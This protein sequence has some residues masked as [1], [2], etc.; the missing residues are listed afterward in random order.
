LIEKGCLAQ[1]RLRDESHKSMVI[2]DGLGERIQRRTVRLS[3]VKVRGVRRDAK[4]LLPQVKK[5]ENHEGNLY[6]MA[7]LAE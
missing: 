1:A 2:Q 4:R 3:R 7:P 6:F 5:I